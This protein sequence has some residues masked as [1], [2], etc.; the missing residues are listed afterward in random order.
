MLIGGANDHGVDFKFFGESANKFVHWDMSG[1]ELVL[2]SSA[3]LSFNDAAGGENILASADGHLEINAGTT[4]D[5]TALTVDINASTAV[6]IDTAA[7]TV[8]SSS[9]SEPVITIKNTNNGAT[10][11]TLKFVNDK[12]AAGA[13]NDV[14]GTISFF[15]DDDNQDNIEFAKIEGVVADATNG[16]ECGALKF[17]VAENDGANTVGLSLTGSTT[18]GQVDVVIGAGSSSVTTVR[19]GLNIP[20]MVAAITDTDKFIV[21]NGGELRYRTGAQLASDIGAVTTSE[22]TFIKKQQIDIGDTAITA[23][24]DGS[25]LHIEGSQ[26]MST[27]TTQD[28]TAGF[29]NQ[30]SI[31]S[32][33]LNAD[34]SGVTTTNASTLY[35]S[36]APEAGNQTI[37]NAYALFVAGGSARFDGFI[38]NT[39]DTVT[40]GSNSGNIT[41]TSADG[42]T[43][44]P[45]ASSVFLQAVAS[46]TDTTYHWDLSSFTGGGNG[47]MLHLVFDKVEDTGITALQVNFNGNSETKRLFSGNGAN[48]YISFTT[49]GQSASLIYMDSAW[50]IINTGATIGNH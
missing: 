18:D 2:G 46:S 36:D 30:V 35:I 32:V 19:G 21:S 14:C 49:T 26:I 10:S 11:G 44:D 20:N 39:Y 24:I 12:G 15:G 27:D 22:N 6:T 43:H 40:Y 9:A 31:E 1:D 17:Y 4:L 29:Y 33:T 34:N 37:T 47:T 38:I 41:A 23:S 48:D 7:V 8:S 50:R 28:T 42:T 45:I 13:D 5:M 3:K 25:H 16:D